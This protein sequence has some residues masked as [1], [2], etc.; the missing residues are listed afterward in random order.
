MKRNHDFTTICDKHIKTGCRTTCP[1]S[2]ACEH[3]HGDTYE[4][5]VERMN[6]AASNY[7]VLDNG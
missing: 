1:L 7:Y 4:V 6:I 2:K 3:K 5:F